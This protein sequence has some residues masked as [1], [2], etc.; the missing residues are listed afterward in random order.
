VELGVPLSLFFEVRVGWFLSGKLGGLV[1]F[2]ALPVV[3][4][5]GHRTLR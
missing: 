5:P 4:D 1:F 3:V 2:W